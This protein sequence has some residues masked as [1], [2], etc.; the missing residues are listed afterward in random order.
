M[1]KIRARQWHKGMR[2]KY[3]KWRTDN[4]YSGPIS[5]GEVAKWTHAVL[6]EAKETWN[7]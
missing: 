1:T 5:H 4:G 3:V 7:E 2:D 6:T